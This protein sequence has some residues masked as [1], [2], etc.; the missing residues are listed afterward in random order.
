MTDPG[1]EGET[2]DPTK[3]RSAAVEALQSAARHSDP[4]E[5]DRLTHYALGL[6]DRARAIRHDARYAA[7]EA[8]EMAAL[9]NKRDIAKKEPYRV[10]HRFFAKLISALRQASPWRTR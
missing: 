5:F 8:R 6:I 10:L 3:L 1:P 9:R 7:L 4:N 2:E